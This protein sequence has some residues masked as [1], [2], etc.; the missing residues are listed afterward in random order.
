MVADT[1]MMASEV[2]LRVGCMK[3]MNHFAI[4]CPPAVVDVLIQNSSILQVAPVVPRDN[5]NL[6]GSS[7]MVLP[8]DVTSLFN[9]VRMQCAYDDFAVFRKASDRFSMYQHD[10]KPCPPFQIALAS[11]EV[12]LDDVINADGINRCFSVATTT[13]CPFGISRCQTFVDVSKG[14]WT[15]IESMGPLGLKLVAPQRCPRGYCEC[16]NSACRLTPL[17]S[18]NRNGNTM[19]SGNRNGTL[20]GGCITNFTQSMNGVSCISNDECG[21]DLWWVWMLSVLGFAAIGLIIT[22][23]S[24]HSDGSLSCLLFYLQIASFASS[25]NGSTG[26]NAILDFFQARSIVAL[27]SRSCYAR[28]MSA[29]DASAAQ[30]IGPVFVLL[31]SLAWTWL[32]QL[33]QPQLQKRNVFL[34]VSYGGTTISAI[35]F[36]FSSASSVVFTLVEC[37][38]YADS[39]VPSVVFVDGT[40]VCFDSRWKGLII[41]VALLCLFPVVFAAALLCNKLPASAHSCLCSAFTERMFYWGA[42]TL[43]FRLLIPLTQFLRVDYPSLLAFVRSFLTL[44]M[45][46]CMVYCRPYK[47]EKTFWVDVTCYTCLIA[48]FGLQ[49]LVESF[50]FFGVVPSSTALLQNVFAG[51]STMIIVLRYSC[52]SLQY[53]SCTLTFAPS[54]VHSSHCVCLRL[55]ED[56]IHVC[57]P[58]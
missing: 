11:N 18:T 53:F 12:W 48:Q 27:F 10:C 24:R 37:T 23:V 38:S 39:G 45:F 34:A 40:V 33:L 36:V 8:R 49:A 51:A 54:Q 29:Y 46:F 25:H 6:S 15:R 13:S 28:N 20:C 5:F 44:V 21:R 9:R 7:L 57:T 3:K 56:K 19:C 26:S 22:P 52:S 4:E 35:L 41:V 55:A 2:V 32:L 17:L 58:V 50:D 1:M 31:F 43:G 47:Y 14:F 16:I 30:L 42:V